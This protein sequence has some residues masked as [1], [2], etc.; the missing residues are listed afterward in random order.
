MEDEILIPQPRS[1]TLFQHTCTS[2]TR[3]SHMVPHKLQG[4]KWNIKGENLVSF[5]VSATRMQ[6]F[7]DKNNVISIPVMT[8]Y[9]LPIGCL[10]TILLLSSLLIV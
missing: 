7:P 9:F 6:A 10:Q 8:S 4:R 1:D 5:T 3:N 2:L